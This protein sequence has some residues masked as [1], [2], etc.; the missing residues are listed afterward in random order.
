LQAPAPRKLGFKERRELDELPAR[1]EALENEQATLLAGMAGMGSGELQAASQRAGEI[2]E[3]L[4]QAY[5]RWT[6]LEARS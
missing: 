2:G 3:L 1:I 6:E 4:E 5:A